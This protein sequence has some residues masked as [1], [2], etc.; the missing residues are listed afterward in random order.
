MPLPTVVQFCC[1]TGDCTAAGVKRD[2]FWGSTMSSAVLRNDAGDIIVPHSVGDTAGDKFTVFLDDHGVNASS[3]IQ[4][5]STSGVPIYRIGYDAPVQK[6]ACD[7]F[8]QD[9][10]PYTKTGKCESNIRKVI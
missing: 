5:R 2:S 6:R 8:T 7:T 1:G 9:G 4:S 10:A 3:A